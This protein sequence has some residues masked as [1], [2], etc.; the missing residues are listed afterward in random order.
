MPP[1]RGLY[2]PNVTRNTAA[3]ILVQEPLGNDGGVVDDSPSSPAYWQSASVM[4]AWQ[5]LE[6]A[7]QKKVRRRDSL[8]GGRALP[9][10]LAP[11]YFHEFL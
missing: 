2:R 5:C 9:V 7:L 6:R 3:R 10:P 11:P 4:L 1:A 8:P